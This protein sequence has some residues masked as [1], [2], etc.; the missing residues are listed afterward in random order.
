MFGTIKIT[1]LGV[2]GAVAAKEFDNPWAQWGAVGLVIAILAWYGIQSYKRELA[3]SKQMVQERKELIEA[4]KEQVK[5]MMEHHEESI[6]RERERY[7]EIHME[8]LVYLK[9]K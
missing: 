1:M 3:Q 9:S 4:H 2:L 6:E 7:H 5:Q 8:L